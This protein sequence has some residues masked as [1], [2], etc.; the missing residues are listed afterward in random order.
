VP[1]VLRDGQRL[2]HVTK[3]EAQDLIASGV[4][5][6]GMAVKLEAALNALAGG[7]QQAIITDLTGIDSK[8]GTLVSI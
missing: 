5:K 2:D 4:A 6:D 3:A 7:V 8:I 1:G